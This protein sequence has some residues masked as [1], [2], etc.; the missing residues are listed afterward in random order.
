MMHFLHEYSKFLLII[1]HFENEL[2]NPIVSAPVIAQC[3]LNPIYRHH[4]YHRHR[5]RRGHDVVEEPEHLGG[6]GIP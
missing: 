3:L 2:E 4:H 1:T 6:A 5:Q